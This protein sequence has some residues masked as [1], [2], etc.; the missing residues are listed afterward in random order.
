MSPGSWDGVAEPDS[1]RGDVD[2]AVE[3]VLA[4]V[5][6]G[7]HRAELCELVDTALDDIAYLVRLGVELGWSPTLVAQTGAVG[8]LV[9][10]FRD[11]GFDATVTQV[12]AEGRLE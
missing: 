5:V 6:A 11:G 1:D 7:G 12:G 8:L 3:D 10:S 4:F 2:G 9:G